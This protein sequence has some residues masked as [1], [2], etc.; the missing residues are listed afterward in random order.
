M[1]RVVLRNSRIEG[2]PGYVHVDLSDDDISIG[3]TF[4]NVT[5]SVSDKCREGAFLQAFF[6]NCTFLLHPEGPGKSAFKDCFFKENCTWPDSAQRPNAGAID[7]LDSP[8][9]HR[10]IDNGVGDY[11]LLCGGTK[12]CFIPYLVA[13]HQMIKCPACGRG[14]NFTEP[15]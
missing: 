4:E 6:D 3:C 7:G 1:G 14:V 12:V 9:E 13:R 15:N 2:H 11:D 5:I 8:P 10:F